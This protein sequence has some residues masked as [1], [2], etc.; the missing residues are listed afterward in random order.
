MEI[1]KLSTCIFLILIIYDDVITSAFEKIKKVEEEEIKESK[2]PELSFTFPSM[3]SFSMP[4]F[5]ISRLP[6]LQALANLGGQY[7]NSKAT[8]TEY[9]EVNI[10]VRE[11][12]ERKRQK[13]FINFFFFLG[14]SETYDSSRL[15]HSL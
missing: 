4:D 13:I 10:C 11:F 7:Q 12:C 2:A 8:K 6:F 9:L 5:G 15:L 14:Y 3:S 1:R